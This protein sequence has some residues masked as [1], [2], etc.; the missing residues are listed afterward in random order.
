MTYHVQCVFRDQ[1]RMADPTWFWVANA[2]GV[3]AVFGIMLTHVSAWFQLC[4]LALIPPVFYVF[5]AFWHAA[6]ASWLTYDVQQRDAALLELYD[7]LEQLQ[8]QESSP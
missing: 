7:T 3:V 8:R 4:L 6:R 5:A 2:C 1:C